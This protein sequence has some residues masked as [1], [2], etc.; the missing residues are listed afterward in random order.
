VRDI[1][2]TGDAHDWFRWRPSSAT[3]P[4]A[5]ATPC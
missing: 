5:E 3:L 1:A 4:L 2:L